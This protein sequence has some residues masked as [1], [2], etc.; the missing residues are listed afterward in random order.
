MLNSGHK[1]AVLKI[2]FFKDMD[3]FEESLRSKFSELEIKP[4]KDHSNPFFE[5]R[6]KNN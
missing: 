6:V 2:I 5:I 4:V 1:N 3:V